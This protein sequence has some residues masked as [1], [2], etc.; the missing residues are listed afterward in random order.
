MIPIVSEELFKNPNCNQSWAT[1][2]K[3]RDAPLASNSLKKIPV[4]FY[5]KNEIQC[6]S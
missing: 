3:S 6:W 2:E 4:D 5:N 1:F